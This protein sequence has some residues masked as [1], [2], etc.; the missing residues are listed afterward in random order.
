MIHLRYL[1][2]SRML[3]VVKPSREKK[4]QWLLDSSK[5][6]NIIVEVTYHKVV[7]NVEGGI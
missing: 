2:V 1:R 5:R 4:K 6:P 3:V 7:G